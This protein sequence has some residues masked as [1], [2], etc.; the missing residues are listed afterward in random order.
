MR[1]I[2]VTGANKGIGLALVCAILD[3]AEDTFVYLGSRDAS[4]GDAARASIVAAHHAWAERVEVIE[5]DVTSDASVA[6]ARAQLETR[7]GGDRL[8]GVVNNAGVGA[9]AGSLA[10]TLEV[11]TRGVRRVCEALAPLVADDGRVVNVTSA[12]GPSFVSKC[13][14]DSKQQLT[15][16]DVEWSQI[17]KV[18][19]EAV[20][21]AGGQGTFAAAGLCD[22]DA[23]GLSKACATAF[24]IAF[25]RA[26]PKLHVNA[27]TPGF[28]E[29]DLTRPY[30]AGAGKTAKEMGMK[31]PSEGTRSPLHLLFGAVE[32]NGRYYGSDAKRSPLD[33]YRSPGDPEYTEP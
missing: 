12:S 26:H 8:Y 24:T 3:H 2:I 20:K 1:R 10:A 4:R 22:G 6:R 29:T 23:Y 19:D 30:L 5:L 32:G 28:I 17:E 9:A 7:L 13:S 27:C 18:M 21:I 15:S 11:N 25:A 14:D 16:R 31:P 33:R